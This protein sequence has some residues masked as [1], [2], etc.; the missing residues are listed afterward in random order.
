MDR[1][2]P[3]IADQ[4]QLVEAAID[5]VVEEHRAAVAD[6]L[7]PGDEREGVGAEAAAGL[8]DQLGGIGAEHL[9]RG[10]GDA[11]ED[12]V[13][14]GL[15]P[16]HPPGREAAA[17]IQPGRTDARGRGDLA[18]DADIALPGAGIDA[19]R[20][21]VEGQRGDVAARR[22]LAQQ[23]GRELR[24][25][26][27]LGAEIIGRAAHRQLEARRDLAALGGHP[28][29]QL[30]ELAGAVHRPGAD[31]GRD[32]VVDLGQAAD[33]VVVVARRP[34]REAADQVDLERRGHVEAPDAGGDEVLEHHLGRVRLDGIGHEA[35]KAVEEL[36]R[37][38]LQLGRGKDHHR[39]LGRE[40]ADD[41][42]RVLPDG[43]GLF[44]AGDPFSPSGRARRRRMRH[45]G[46]DFAGEK[47]GTAGFA[48]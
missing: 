23:L 27:E 40:H 47:G 38:R 41:L 25:G 17:D 13:E 1:E 44:H 33:R 26:A 7:D 15:D 48:G 45:M 11:G 6:R 34:R 32:R 4:R 12:R 42:G 39:V 10:P 28:G 30:G 29:D 35:G 31:A 19:L 21:R 3:E 9:G 14:V 36:P 5:A 8:A 20:A 16:A 43:A 37:R 18:G 2:A 46:D 24:R 22:D